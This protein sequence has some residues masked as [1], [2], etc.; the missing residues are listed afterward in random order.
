[1]RLLTYLTAV[2]HPAAANALAL[3]QFDTQLPM[4]SEDRKYSTTACLTARL[5]RHRWLR[6]RRLAVGDL[7]LA[8]QTSGSWRLAGPRR[9]G[10]SAVG[11]LADQTADGWR[12]VEGRGW[13]V[14]RLGGWLT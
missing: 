2:C 9:F 6:P 14:W 11:R 5:N 8:D 1:M 4:S 7:R 12:L 3:Q 10:C 13:A